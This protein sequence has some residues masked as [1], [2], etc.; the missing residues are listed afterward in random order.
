M[1]IIYYVLTPIVIFLLN[2]FFKK[3]NIIFNYSGNKH[4][5]LVGE[6]SIP[7]VGGIYLIIFLTIVLAQNYLTLYFF[8]FFIFLIGVS[9]DIKFILSPTKRLLLQTLLTIFFI[10]YLELY[11]SETRVTFID[12]MLTNFYFSIFFSC[13]CLIILMNGSNFIDGLNGLVLGYYLI[14]LL[15]LYNLDLFI[16][17]DLNDML[18]NY[19]LYLILVLLIFNF[20][21]HFYLGDSG[22]YLLSSLVGSIL[23]MIYDQNQIFSPFFVV[24]LLWYPCFENLFSIIRKFK[25][26]RSPINAD[27]NHLHQ[28]M[29]Y[30]L[31]KKFKTRNIISNNCSSMIINIYNLIIFLIASL[32]ISNTQFLIFLIIINIVVYTSCYIKFFRYKYKIK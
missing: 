22:T 14:V 5:K 10:Y 20:L 3:K 13:F 30:F 12:Q 19:L 15:I 6:K 27:S 32:N 28:L 4:Q 25:V 11:I 26:K 7:L 16:Y 17:L 2:L 1:E 29:F 24:L 31:K 23:I 9:S 18:I 8:L 21:N